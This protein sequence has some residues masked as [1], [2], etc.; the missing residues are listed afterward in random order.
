MAT[1]DST[2]Y[3]A[4]DAD[5]TNTAAAQDTDAPPEKPE[6]LVQLEIEYD[7]L[8]GRIYKLILFIY[9]RHRKRL[10]DQKENLLK[11][12]L[13]LMWAYADILQN[14]L[15]LEVDLII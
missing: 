8:I 5:T 4:Q 15:L 11:N 1:E 2:P 6:L 14:R 13:E 3:A 10:S 7:D 9:D 12:Q